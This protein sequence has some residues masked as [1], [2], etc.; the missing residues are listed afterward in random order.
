MSEKEMENG[1]AD[2]RNSEQW[3]L[4]EL[5]PT[6]AEEWERLRAFLD[7]QTGEIEAMLATVEPLFRRGHELVV[8]NYDYLL[9]HEETAAILG[10]ESG[11][12]PEHLAERRRF[13]TIWLARTLGLD[14]SHD[15]ALYLF[16]A[17][18][19]HAGHGPREIHV[20]DLY[21]TGAISLV[22]ATFA[23]FLQEEMP[24]SPVVP[25]ALAGWNKLLTLHLHMMLFG[26][27]VAQAWEAG[28]F[29]VEIA[30]FGKIR[31]LVRRQRVQMGLR[32][33]SSMRDVLRKFF[34]YYPQLRPEVFDIAWLEGERLDE[35]GK[36]WLTVKQGYQVR[37]GWRV[38]LNGRDVAY[39]GGLAQPVTPGDEVA[40]FPPGR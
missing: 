22:N 4:D 21:V 35:T 12:D 14:L 17:G 32:Q 9:Q 31:A 6:P 2:V 5:Q 7:L 8:D 1:Q 24:D 39:S 3:Q 29:E 33:G 18:Q 36:P 27:R 23:R 11:P 34:D 10:W 37:R 40:I 30:L 28:D 26:Y 13:F 25:R 20:P 38:L 15:F 19:K 16:K